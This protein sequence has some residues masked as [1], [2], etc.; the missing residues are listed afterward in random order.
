MAISFFGET[1][2]P[3]TDNA[4]TPLGSATPHAIVPPASMVSGHVVL[5][6]VTAR[7]NT[8]PAVSNAGGQTWTSH[9]ANTNGATIT[10]RL[11]SCVFNG[12]WSAN[13]SFTTGSTTDGVCLWMGVFAGV[14]NS[15]IFDVD[16]TDL[17]LA[18]ATSKTLTGFNTNYNGSWAF[19]M[20]GEPD[21]NALSGQDAGWTGPDGGTGALSDHVGN[22][23]GLD[24][25]LFIS[26]KT[27]TTAGATGNNVVALNTADVGAGY[28]FALRDASPT[29]VLNTPTEAQ[30][31]SDT[32][33]TFD[34]TGTDGG[35]DSIEYNV[36]VDTVNTFDSQSSVIDTYATSNRDGDWGLL[37][38]VRIGTGQS[39]VGTGEIISNAQFLLSKT[40]SPTGNATAKIYAHSGTYGTSSIPTGSALATSDNFDISTLNTTPTLETLSFSGANQITLTNGTNYVLTIEWNGGDASNLLS[41]GRDTSSPTHGGNS[42]TQAAGGSWSASS[43]TDN[44]FILNAISSPLL[45]K[46]SDTPDATFTNPDTGGD[47]HPFNSGENIQY[48]VQAGDALSVGTYYWRV[49]AIDPNGSNTYGAWSSTRS[50]TITSAVADTDNFFRFFGP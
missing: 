14:D 34:F 28:Y 33:P 35:G 2:V 23:G 7:N 27:Q 47:T 50:F 21:D 45:S 26:K 11:F 43:G 6:F 20:W 38:G 5:V 8:A 36:Q 42:S 19:F 40:G 49:R 18:S 30:S 25:G 39:F 41:V 3:A 31:V 10:G 9:A 1:W 24:I 29:V 46:F 13:P 12:T 4:T 48:Q 15:D 22:Q 44:I 37:A 17:D 32:T 16:P